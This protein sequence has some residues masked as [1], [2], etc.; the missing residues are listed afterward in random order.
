ME[1]TKAIF[2]ETLEIGLG[3]A[4][5]RERLGIQEDVKILDFR[6]YEVTAL[7]VSEFAF[8][9]NGG[10]Q[11]QQFANG[12]KVEAPDGTP[13]QNSALYA[14]IEVPVEFLF[15]MQIT[16]VKEHCV[17]IVSEERNNK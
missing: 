4:E 6:V 16:A 14:R 9:E 8:D 10:C 5:N 11:I 2:E 7:G 15:G 13:I 1:N 17:D 12:T 3:S